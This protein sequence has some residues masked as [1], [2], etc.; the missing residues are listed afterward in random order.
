M[1][2]SDDVI[3]RVV[4]ASLLDD[5]YPPIIRSTLLSRERFRSRLGFEIDVQLSF[6]DT[7]VS[8]SRSALFSCVRTV[9]NDPHQRPEIRDQEGN[10]WKIESINCESGLTKMAQDNRGLILPEFWMLINNPSIRLSNFERVAFDL[11]LPTTSRFYWLE[12]LKLGPL[13]D[14]QVDEVREDIKDTPAHI[15][16]CIVGE[17]NDRHNKTETLVPRS[18]R[19]FSRLVGEYTEENTLDAYVQGALKTHVAELIAGN[20]VEG[21]KQALLLSAHSSIPSIIDLGCF[22]ASEIQTIFEELEQKGD[23]LSQLGAIELGLSIFDQYPQLEVSVAGMIRQILDDDPAAE[24]SRFTLL[25]A[26]VVF[27]EGE[28]SY[29]KTLINTP[30]FWRRLATFA[31]ASLIERCVISYPVDIELLNQWVHSGRGHQFYLQTLCDLRLEPKWVPDFISPNQLKA[32]F[33]ARITNAAQLNEDKISLPLM[34]ELIFGEDARSVIRI[35]A[36]HFPEC[37][38]PGPLEGGTSAATVMP[39]EFAIAVNDALSKEPVDWQSFVGLINSALIFRLDPKFADQAVLT[40]QRA[41]HYVKQGA[42]KSDLFDVFSG[43]AS[44]ASL[45]R[46]PQL[47][48]ELRV[49]IRRTKATGAIE[50]NAENFFRIGMIAASAHSELKS[51]CEFVGEWITELAY[52]D[53]KRE[54]AVRLHSHVQCLCSIVPELWTTLGRAEAALSAVR[55]RE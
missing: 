25:S 38:F 35:N 4:V 21:L 42:E 45:T 28:V 39:P 2:N 33:V 10:I 37:V 52:A 13:N 29:A 12:K 32:E 48:Q 44:V 8:V 47:S 3:N 54:D 6:G 50:V 9:L 49:L 22:D 36:M 53:L 18:I 17:A 46:A 1:K 34:Q 24:E 41:K 16:K 5:L 11:N 14:D 23:R 27:V 26:L 55:G 15:S 51:W 30:P 7:G 40:L 20:K 43:L 31:Q 19:Y